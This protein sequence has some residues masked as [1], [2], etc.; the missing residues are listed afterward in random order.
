MSSAR[1]SIRLLKVNRTLCGNFSVVGKSQARNSIQWTGRSSGGDGVIRGPVRCGWGGDG[2]TVAG[3]GQDGQQLSTI[4]L[5][6]GFA[7]VLDAAQLC[8]ALRP[9][10]DNGGKHLVGTDH[11]WWHALLL[12]AFEPP[13]T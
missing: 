4:F 2:L 1:L 10:L 11:I 6:F 12:A 13:V 5:Q 7:E 9:R 3:R 8:Q